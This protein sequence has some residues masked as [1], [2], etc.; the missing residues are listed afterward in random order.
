MVYLL[1]GFSAHSGLKVGQQYVAPLPPVGNETAKEPEP[2][3]VLHTSEVVGNHSHFT[4]CLRFKAFYQR[5][6]TVLV[7]AYSEKRTVAVVGVDEVKRHLYFKYSVPGDSDELARVN[8][9]WLPT[10]NRWDH[11]CF[12]KS[13]LR[14]NQ[15][16]NFDL[17]V[18][19]IKHVNSKSIVDWRKIINLLKN[20]S[21]QVL[22]SPRRSPT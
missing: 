17:Y 1:P 21:L 15:T 9:D 19:G 4:L 3:P 11:L 2:L 5:P 8:F 20:P 18:N 7:S 14:E 22:R 13:K 12:V 16:V 6:E 10:V